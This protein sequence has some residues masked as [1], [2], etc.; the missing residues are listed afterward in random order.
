MTGLQESMGFPLKPG[1]SIEEAKDF[2]CRSE[3]TRKFQRVHGNFSLGSTN[4]KGML[5]RGRGSRH[6]TSR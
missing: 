3:Q 5:R 1:R 2:Q 6:K 4:G